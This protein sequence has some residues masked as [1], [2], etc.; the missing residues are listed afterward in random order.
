MAGP[1]LTPPSTPSSLPR[2]L[3]CPRPCSHQTFTSRK[4]TLDGFS[5]FFCTHGIDIIEDPQNS[6][7]IY[8]HA[9][10]HAP[11]DDYVKSRNASL[12]A[13]GKADSR[14]EIFHHV[15][16]SDTATHVRTVRHNLI[17]TPNDLIATGPSSFFVTNDHFYREGTMRQLEDV[18]TRATSAW[19]NILHVV[20]NAKED[21][22]V[23]VGAVFALHGL[24]NNN[25]LGRRPGG[26]TICDASGGVAYLATI[27]GRSLKIDSQIAYK[28]T[29]D[30][31]SW[32]TDKYPG[33]DDRSGIV[34]AGLAKAMALH[35]A[36]LR[37]A[38]VPPVVWLS[39]GSPEKGWNTSMLFT[40]NGLSLSSA[41]AAVMISI[42]PATNGGKKQ[43][44]LFMS[45]FGSLRV[46]ATKVDL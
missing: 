22:F 15:L 26:V 27:E 28:S 38:A 44:W 29:I 10:N 35:E 24:H 46:V 21:G 18:G 30:N 9:V 1:L 16:G 19:S 33:D 6:R 43:A 40:D 7:A 11:T 42:D 31:P 3:P 5:S 36:V 4:L 39:S 20:S 17:Q 14:I 34:Q 32:F 41:S 37:D 23:G 25:G 8:I 45:G 12:P 2:A 13:E